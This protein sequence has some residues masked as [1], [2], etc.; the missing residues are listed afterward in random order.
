[1]L[2]MAH[3]ARAAWR[4]IARVLAAVI[5]LS[6][7]TL[8]VAAGAASPG[9]T[10]RVSVDGPVIGRVGPGFVGFSYEKDRI[11]AGVFDPGNRALVS[12][13]RLLGPSVLRVGGNLVD[14]VNWNPHGAGGSAR[15]VAPADVLR[16][17]AF[18]RAT[19]WTAL[20]GINLKTNTAA[21]AAAEARFVAGAL[22][23]SL[24]AF[25]IGNE[26]GG[27]RSEQQ[28]EQ[29][30]EQYAT[31]IR[32][33]V[34]GAVFD[35]PGTFDDPGWLPG[36]AA[37]EASHGLV[38]LGLHTYIGGPRSASIARLVTA[39]SLGKISVD[40]TALARAKT[41][42]GI[43]SLRITEANSFVEGGVRGVSDTAAAALWSLD[44]LY[45]VAAHD[46][47]GV[48]FH[49]GTST[50][51]A[52][53]Y[54]PIAFAGL[55]PIGVQSVYY[56]GLLWTLAGTGPLRLASTVGSPLV[57]AWG[58][59]DNVIV[60]NKCP[61][62]VRA[63]ITLPGQARHA[64][65]YL[66]TGDGSLHGTALTI[67]GSPVDVDGRFTPDPATVPVAGRTVAI[68]VPAASAALLVPITD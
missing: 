56:G 10:V 55:H 57:S 33:A 61:W 17:A 18:L 21:N 46:G 58:I 16:L 60:N 31:A 65:E 45:G 30:F 44:F 50:Q 64:R 48:N 11:G 36:F 66:M 3:Q 34:P 43:R 28:Y 2:G 35:G 41:A 68:D 29:S 13:F 62:R 49:G 27:Y 47:D 12:L 22:G 39:G 24:L 23:G 8:G 52:L 25:E 51:F 59:G 32:R 19:G 15:E 38:M 5:V 14:I 40:E 6:G 1:M 20:Y 42:N 26:P 7:L 9:Q 37:R 54:T 67:A 4:W 53:N 63:T